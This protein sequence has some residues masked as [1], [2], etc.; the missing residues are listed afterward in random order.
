MRPTLRTL[1]WLYSREYNHIRRSVLS[2]R[3]SKT[4]PRIREILE[5]PECL[6]APLL[7]IL[8]KKPWESKLMKPERWRLTSNFLF[9]LLVELYAL[10]FKFFVMRYSLLSCFS[11]PCDA[12][13]E[14]RFIVRR[15]FGLEKG[16]LDF[17]VINDAL[18]H[19]KILQCGRRSPWNRTHKPY[20]EA[21]TIHVQCQWDRGMF[22]GSLS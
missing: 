22:W 18:L 11:F 20:E 7:T 16:S 8:S 17:F 4:A 2:E 6:L 3:S 13:P 5:P 21:R 10:V 1:H 15:G 12:L 9:D 14:F 19:N